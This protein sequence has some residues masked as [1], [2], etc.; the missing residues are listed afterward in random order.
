MVAQMM[1][2][3]SKGGVDQTAPCQKPNIYITTRIRTKVWEETDIFLF[4]PFAW[5]PT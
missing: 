3:P 4:V 1:N 5:D 2:E